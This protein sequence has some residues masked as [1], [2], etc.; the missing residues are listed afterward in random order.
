MK[1]ATYRF[2]AGTSLVPKNISWKLGVADRIT[3]WRIVLKALKYRPKIRAYALFIYSRYCSLGGT[4]RA[5]E[6]VLLIN[7]V[8][9]HHVNAAQWNLLLEATGLWMYALVGVEQV[10]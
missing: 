9:L 7:L 1:N 8:R 3:L 2:W 5:A 6:P 10:V 4:L